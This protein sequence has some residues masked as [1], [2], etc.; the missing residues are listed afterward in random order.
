[1]NL[2]TLKKRAKYFSKHIFAC[3]PR[4]DTTH[5]QKS[6]VHDDIVR[7][8]LKP[9]TIKLILVKPVILNLFLSP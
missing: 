9:A 8:D 2:P 4:R 5:P 1:M 3:L 7:V 6:R